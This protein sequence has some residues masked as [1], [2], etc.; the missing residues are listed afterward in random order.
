[1]KSMHVTFV[2]TKTIEGIQTKKNQ[3]TCT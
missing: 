3:I 2:L 1:M